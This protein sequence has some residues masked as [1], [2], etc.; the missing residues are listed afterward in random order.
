MKDLYKL[1][2]IGREANKAE[3]KKAYRDLAKKYHPDRNSGNEEAEKKFIEVNKAYE[4]L[5]DEKLKKEYD[6]KLL[7]GTS[8]SKK[9][10]KETFKNTGNFKFDPSNFGNM[11]DSFFN[12]EVDEK[13]SDNKVKKKVDNMFNS[14]FMGGKK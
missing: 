5:S 4:I 10:K 9:V 6:E 1:L 3:I 2:G 11:F 12:P 7:S 13:A 8:E 14:Y